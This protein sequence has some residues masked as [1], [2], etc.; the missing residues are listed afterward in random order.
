MEMENQSLGSRLL[1]LEKRKLQYMKR[2]HQ[3]V[4]ESL[5][6]K[7]K[8]H[9]LPALKRWKSEKNEWKKEFLK[10]LTEISKN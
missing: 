3:E 2:I 8:E 4:R 1:Q 10:T 6:K 7:T 9:Y 5:K